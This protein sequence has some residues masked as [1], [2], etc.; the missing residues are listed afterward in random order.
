MKA[1]HSEARKRGRL[2]G[3][4]DKCVILKEVMCHLY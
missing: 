3:K 2:G 4:K 1:L